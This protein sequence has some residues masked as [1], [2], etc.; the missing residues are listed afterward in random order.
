MVRAVQALIVLAALV[1]LQGLPGARSP[2]PRPSPTAAYPPHS[3]PVYAV[4]LGAAPVLGPT[5]ALVTVVLFGDLECALT[6]RAYATLK[7]LQQANPKEVR[8][9]F[10][11]L[12][13]TS[14]H[15]GA[16]EAALVALEAQAQ[17]R[18][19]P[20]LDA[21]FAGSISVSRA[22][23]Q[24]HAGRAGLK[25]G[26]AGRAAA[27]TA[28]QT[29][30][31]ADLLAA[32]GLQVT[33]TPTVFVNG[34][35]A[36]GALSVSELRTILGRERTRASTL[37]SGGH[38]RRATVYDDLQQ[39]ATGAPRPNVLV[40]LSGPGSPRPGRPHPIL[41]GGR[42]APGG[43]VG[44]TPAQ[45]AADRLD[46]S[47]AP[48]LGSDDAMVTVILFTNFRCYYS[49]YVLQAVEEL[50]RE[51]PG[52]V[53]LHLKFHGIQRGDAVVLPAAQAALAAHAGGRFW[54]YA[55]ILFRNRWRLDRT[56]LETFAGDAD[57]DLPSLRAALA[58]PVYRAR[59]EQDV[60]E[61]ARFLKGNK[62]CPVVWINGQVVQGYISAHNLKDRLRQAMNEV[63][64]IRIRPLL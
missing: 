42:F 20:F 34:T 7:A 54:E 55:E 46:L 47:T 25:A 53:K 44:A 35:R 43:V 52:V 21:V 4:P 9:A 63:K 8:L 6:R 56:S 38:A 61:S 58:S 64:G 59:V 30:L 11:H 49:E 10:R 36:G 24:R 62:A 12:P 26:S 3:V 27:V 16:R 29:R 51:A 45:P 41:V 50:R 17:G 2:R 23:L 40:S 1:G 13:L 18:F 60:A 57:V 37:I 15:S 39:R 5:D 33:G 32:R 19:W 31:T 22:D 14:V 48:S 28:N